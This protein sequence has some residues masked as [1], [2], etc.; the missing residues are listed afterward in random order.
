MAPLTL[1]CDHAGYWGAASDLE[2]YS[3]ARRAS[4]ARRAGDFGGLHPVPNAGPFLDWSPS[5]EVED[6]DGPASIETGI[7]TTTKNTTQRLKG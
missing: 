5:R 4:L 1:T 7:G 3:M 6:V 2:L